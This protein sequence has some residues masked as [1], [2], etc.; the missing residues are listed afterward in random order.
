MFT[1]SSN[2]ISN[3]RNGIWGKKVM[4]IVYD[5]SLI[6]TVMVSRGDVSYFQLLQGLFC[7]FIKKSRL[8]HLLF[9]DKHQGRVVI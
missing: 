2:D 3:E 4:F 7:D 5:F 1:H 8:N 6:R 9:F